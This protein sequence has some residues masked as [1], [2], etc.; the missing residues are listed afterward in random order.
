MS[1]HGAVRCL[2]RPPFEVAKCY[3]DCFFVFWHKILSLFL[4]QYI[5][6]DFYNLQGYFLALKNQKYNIEIVIL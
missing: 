5:I 1:D 4:T 3:E 2:A 6:E